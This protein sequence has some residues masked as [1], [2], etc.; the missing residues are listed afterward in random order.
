MKSLR[1][2]PAAKGSDTNKPLQDRLAPSLCVRAEVSK[3][4]QARSPVHPS[5]PLGE[6]RSFEIVEQRSFQIISRYPDKSLQLRRQAPPPLD[7]G[8]TSR[9]IFSHPVCIGG[10]AAGFTLVELM[11][12]T[13]II[14]ILASVATPAY[15]NYKN[16]AIQ[17][18]AIEALLR[19][20][21]DQEIFWAE[22]SRYAR[23]IRR[24]PSFGNTTGISISTPNGYTIAVVTANANSFKVRATKT[25]FSCAQPDTITITE[26]PQKAPR[27]AN[28]DALKFSLFK[29]LF[30]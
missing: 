21:M 16:R 25:Y 19:A 5:I 14:A 27:I 29:W 6:R 17:G 11:V 12:I 30:N 28:T 22:N 23:T 2:N 8:G 9:K 13:A 4:E 7:R 24:L 26:D 3:H 1:L 20:R 10:G 15:I 18:E